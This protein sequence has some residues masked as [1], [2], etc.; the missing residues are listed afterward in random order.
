MSDLSAI[1]YFETAKAITREHAAK[2]LA[3]AKPQPRPDF[4]S[5]VYVL[6]RD[7]EEYEIRIGVCYDATY[8]AEYI[9]GTWENSY[10][11]IGEMDI[12]DILVLDDNPAGITDDMVKEA[13]ENAKERLTEEAWEDY[14][15]KKNERYE[16]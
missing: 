8:Q 3:K 16:P 12:T 11:A 6:D 7:G 15:S 14:H 10:P 5:Y 1:D 9:S 13:A 4:E 2:V